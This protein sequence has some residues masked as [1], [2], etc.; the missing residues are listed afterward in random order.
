MSFYNACKAGNI[1]A[2]TLEIEKGASD[3][4][5]G[6]IIACNGGFIDLV[7]LMIEKG[8]DNWN[9]GLRS[10]CIYGHITLVNLMIKKGANNF[11]D[12]LLKAFDNQH[13]EVVCLMLNYA[14]KCPTDIFEWLYRNGYYTTIKLLI[15]R[16]IVDINLAFSL[17]CAW[18][19]SDIV[20][21]LI[22]EGYINL[23]DKLF[24]AC[25]YGETQIA[26]TLIEHGATAVN[27]GLDASCQIDDMN[28]AKIMIE[29]G[30]TNLDVLSLTQKYKI[31]NTNIDINLIKHHPA[32]KE[33]ID[34]RHEYCRIFMI[35]ADEILHNIYK[36]KQIYDKN[37]LNIVAHYINYI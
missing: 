14:S 16:S 20:D 37:V 36:N 30:A 26:I 29:K 11:N 6:L 3:W 21:L 31:C 12:G 10:A 32:Y 34:N 22:K 5:N 17:A 35:I 8:A 33:I 24:V 4:N 1:K 15:R 27:D 25:T 18:R 13:T 9:Y 7:K 2:V 19:C 23:N 28:T